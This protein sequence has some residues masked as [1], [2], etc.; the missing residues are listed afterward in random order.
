MEYLSTF[1]FPKIMCICGHWFESG[2]QLC[3][4]CDCCLCG[5]PF[6]NDNI[7]PKCDCCLFCG[8]VTNNDRKCFECNSCFCGVELNNDHTCP[9]CDISVPGTK[10]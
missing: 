9:D 5:T 2:E 1:Q 10:K 4:E 3:P 8:A 7:C 6:N